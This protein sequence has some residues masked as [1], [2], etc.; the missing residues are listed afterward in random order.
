MNDHLNWRAVQA[1]DAAAQARS[2]LLT[3]SPETVREYVRV[4][5]KSIKTA[6]G[7]DRRKLL[8]LRELLEDVETHLRRFPEED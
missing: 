2:L 3:R 7:E 1:I 6:A 5:N 8:M 4:L